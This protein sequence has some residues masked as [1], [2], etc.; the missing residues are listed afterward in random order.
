MKEI[1]AFGYCS[2]FELLNVLEGVVG[3]TKDVMVKKVML[4]QLCHLNIQVKSILIS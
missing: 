2:E 1:D 3:R 4:P